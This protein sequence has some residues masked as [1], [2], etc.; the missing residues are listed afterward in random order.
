MEEAG[1]CAP[2]AS[3]LRS[4]GTSI[5]MT[6]TIAAGARLAVPGNSGVTMY[7]QKQGE[8]AV[9]GCL[10]FGDSK[11]TGVVFVSSFECAESALICNKEYRNVSKLLGKTLS[12]L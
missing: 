5:G 8:A 9:I 11:T 3:H 4:K 1:T 7:F 6:R 2:L 10:E 12:T